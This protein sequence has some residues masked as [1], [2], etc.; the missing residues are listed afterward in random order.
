MKNGNKAIAVMYSGGLDSTL[1]AFRLGQK[2]KEVHLL[3]FDVSLTIGINNCK[4]NID[5]IQRACPNAKIIHNIINIDHSRNLFWKDFTRDYFKYNN[6]TSPAILCLSCKMSMLAETIKYC[7]DNGIDK[8]SNGLTGSQSDHPEH[9]PAIVNRFTKY[10]AQYGIRFINEIYN[11][12]TREME[13]KE[14]K[15]H[16]IETGTIIGASNVSHQPRCFVGVYS[17]LWKAY[18]K[19]DPKKVLNYFDK[20]IT[21]MDEVLKDYKKVKNQEILNKSTLVDENVEFKFT[22][23]FGPV[24]DKVIGTMLSPVWF[25]S[26]LIFKMKR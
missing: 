3:T 10:M 5:N 12:P 14:L 13:K 22:H 2:Y 17:T 26:R 4:K 16:G 18:R 21:V 15:E 8:I 19:F 9:M 6:G 20:K 1:S 11:I 7:L 24:L 25:I 23:E